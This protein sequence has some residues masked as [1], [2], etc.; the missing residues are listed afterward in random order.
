MI[1]KLFA[2]LSTLSLA[3]ASP[4]VTAFNPLPII[5]Y[6]I[7]IVMDLF[8]KTIRPLV[9]DHQIQIWSAG[10]KVI[11]DVG[12]PICKVGVAGTQVFNTQIFNTVSSEIIIDICDVIMLVAQKPTSICRGTI[13]D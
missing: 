12:C 13:N 11:Q 1:K 3:L 4:L 6:P 10:T 8:F 5:N 9:L 2:L 7:D